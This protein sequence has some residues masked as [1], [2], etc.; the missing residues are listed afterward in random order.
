MNEATLHARS[1]SGPR[2][3]P[4][5]G[6]CFRF[7]TMDGKR[8]VFVNV[9]GHDSVGRPQGASGQTVG[10]DWISVHGVDNLQIPIAVGNV[11]EDDEGNEP[12]AAAGNAAK[13][14]KVS[15]VRRTPEVGSSTAAR[16]HQGAMVVDVVIHPCITTLCE[17]AWRI[18]DMNDVP[19]LK[20]QIIAR[21]VALSMDWVRREAGIGAAPA[22]VKIITDMAFR[23]PKL[24]EAA[25]K[26]RQLGAAM[27]SLKDMSPEQLEQM[28]KEAGVAGATSSGA[29]A[30]AGSDGAD[31]ETDTRTAAFKLNKGASNE[32]G[33]LPTPSG[34]KR[35]AGIQVLSTTEDQQSAPAQTPGAMAATAIRPGF[36]NRKEG[37]GLY[38]EE[39]TKEGVLP[40]GAGDPL[41]Y[42]PKSLRSKFKVVDARDGTAVGDA[43]AERKKAE[44]AGVPLE[45]DSE[46]FLKSLEALGGAEDRRLKEEEA[47]RRRRLE[48]QRRQQAEDEA[49]WQA[50]EAT[51][52]AHVSGG[53]TIEEV[54]PA[55]V[56]GAWA[57]VT[58]V[59][60]DTAGDG[61]VAVSVT[62]MPTETSTPPAPSSMKDVDVT[63]EEGSITVRKGGEEGPLLFGIGRPDAPSAPLAAWLCGASGPAGIPV[64]RLF[65]LDDETVTAKFARAQRRITVRCVIRPV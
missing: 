14:S 53:V 65:A 26:K 29:A 60:A 50:I 8:R 28:M 48:E 22:S 45:Q 1:G 46:S 36:L 41:G 16:S 27:D 62:V 37:P 51:A 43:M 54:P 11:V 47:A 49:R 64:D 21:I 24:S 31:A 39:G 23:P 55:Q 9:C 12:Q 3:G 18:G 7:K 44:A 6:F 52:A 34:S 38:G 40:D 20:Q 63:A 10:D 15:E 33:V 30:E 61:A 35:S 4:Q 56:V 59:C 5:R 17:A 13:A 25:K 57:A 19:K 32:G 42:M 2:S 58:T